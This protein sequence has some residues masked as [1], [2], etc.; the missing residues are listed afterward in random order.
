MIVVIS[1]LNVNGGLHSP[2]M[3]LVEEQSHLLEEKAADAMMAVL[4]FEALYPTDDDTFMKYL[5]DDRDDSAATS[6]SSAGDSVFGLDVLFSP[7]EQDMT[8]L[9]TLSSEESGRERKIAKNTSFEKCGTTSGGEAGAP[10]RTVAW[11][12]QQRVQKHRPGKVV[13]VM[14]VE[15]NVAEPAPPKRMTSI[16]KTNR[17]IDVP[18]ETSRPNNQNQNQN[19]DPLLHGKLP[20]RRTISQKMKG[21][22]LKGTIVRDRTKTFEGTT[23]SYAKPEPPP[24]ESPPEE[25]VTAVAEEEITM[26]NEK[27]HRLTIVSYGVLLVCSCFVPLRSNQL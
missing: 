14:A 15:E 19:P 4:G 17:I 16:K 1:C 11:F 22:L 23:S 20:R 8:E 6:T 26:E 18:E 21:W 27:T 2:A 10:K 12:H 3:S 5:D 9:K 7:G 25:E 13:I 24:W